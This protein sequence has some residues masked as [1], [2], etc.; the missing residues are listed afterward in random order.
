MHILNIPCYIHLY[1]VLYL[2]S[3]NTMRTLALKNWWKNV[4]TLKF[5]VCGYQIYWLEMIIST[6]LTL[7]CFLHLTTKWI[8]DKTRL[9][10]N[11]IFFKQVSY[12]SFAIR[13]ALSERQRACLLMQTVEVA[14]WTV[15]VGCVNNCHISLASCQFFLTH[16]NLGLVIMSSWDNSLDFNNQLI[17]KQ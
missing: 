8:K 11:S 9:K 15:F 17:K 10:V 12:F 6:L 14:L 3:L 1:F 4:H 16:L 2:F 13:Q 7:Y 5:V